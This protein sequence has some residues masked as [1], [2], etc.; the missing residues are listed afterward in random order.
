[1]SLSKHKSWKVKGKQYFK[2]EIRITPNMIKELG[3][4]EGEKLE[5]YVIRKN[6]VVKKKKK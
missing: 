3:W 5:F 4:D 2:W 1:M 6:L